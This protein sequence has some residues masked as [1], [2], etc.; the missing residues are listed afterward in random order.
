TMSMV[1]Q[2]STSARSSAIRSVDSSDNS[3][4]MASSFTT[5]KSTSPPVRP[6]NRGGAGKATVLGVHDQV[7]CRRRAAQQHFSLLDLALS[8]TSG[9]I[10]VDLARDQ[11]RL[12]RAAH[13]F[14]TGAWK[15]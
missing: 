5:R 10:H 12:T 11:L 15:R 3:R 8:D 4:R 14:T 1:G 6:V 9:M 13:A 7:V 2:V